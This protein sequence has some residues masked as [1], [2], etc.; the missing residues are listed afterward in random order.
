MTKRCST[1]WILSAAVIV[2]AGYVTTY[3]FPL[4]RMFPDASPL[5]ISEADGW[6]RPPIAAQGRLEPEKGVWM[7]GGIPGEEIA[8]LDV[9]VGQ[10]VKKGDLLAVLGSI[11]IRKKEHALARSKLSQAE[12]QLDFEE[13]LAELKQEMA[14]LAVQ[15]AE[16]GKREI[17]AQDSS[18]D[19][20]QSRLTL[21]TARLESLKKLR[22]HA[23]EA[24]AQADLEQQQ[25]LVRQLEVELQQGDIQ[26][27]V[28]RE[29]QDLA[30]QAAAKELEL[31]RLQFNRLDSISP[32]AA[33]RR[34]AELADLAAQASRVCAPRNG[35]ILE[36]YLH[37]GE[38]VATTPILKMADLSSMVCVAE[39]HEASLKRLPGP[40]TLELPEGP[41][42]DLL[43]DLPV[44]MR[45]QALQ[46]PLTG[47][48]V[49]V[50]RLIGAP[51]L[52]DPNPL[53]ASDRRTARVRIRLDEQS[54]EV[55]RRFVHLQV[56]VTIAPRPDPGARQSS[57]APDADP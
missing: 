48:V 25:L 38:R 50:S 56:D 2:A 35:K 41:E 42:R 5:G 26:L 51:S 32:I 18:V 12:R 11:R 47:R 39:I 52:R 20:G 22:E 55:A 40:K 45:S 8:Q 37:R 15:R 17:A 44:E 3:W 21:A 31:A 33:L 23:G 7:V 13:R 54:A 29:N 30:Y 9:Q 28:A 1:V 34:A 46:Q 10:D 24:V 36:I 43:V 53:A 6:E 14:Q 19:V 57:S 4:S 16:E 49:H 27:Q